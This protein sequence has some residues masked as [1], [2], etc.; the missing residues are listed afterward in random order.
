MGRAISPQR[1]NDFLGS[2]QVFSSAVTDIIEEKLL[3]DISGD[4]LTLS[5]FRLLKLVANTG[6]HSIG[7]VAAFLGVSNAAASKAV[8]KL[9]R[10]GL[11]ARAEGVTDRRAVDL[12]LTTQSLKLLDAYDTARNCKLAQIFQSFTRNELEQTEEILDRLSTGILGP[13]AQ[14]AEYCFRCGI[15]FRE[16]CSL[17]KLPGRRCTY[18]AHRPRLRHDCVAAEASPTA[19]APAANADSTSN[20]MRRS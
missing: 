16:K 2:A 19:N 17:R 9:V 20:G 12:S 10:R 3:R 15:Y 4:A 8:D 5:Q 11:I 13:T 18:V 6:A 1:V 14:A 7:D